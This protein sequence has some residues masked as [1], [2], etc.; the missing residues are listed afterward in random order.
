MKKHPSTY[1][2]VQRF[3][4]TLLLS[5]LTLAWAQV[6]EIWTGTFRYMAD[7]NIFVACSGERYEVIPDEAYLVLEQRY[8]NLIKDAGEALFVVLSGQVTPDVNMEG[9]LTDMFLLESVVDIRAD[10]RCP[11]QTSAVLPADDI[12][13]DG[14][15]WLILELP[16]LDQNLI[17][18]VPVTSLPYLEFRREGVTGMLTGFAGCNQISAAYLNRDARLLIADITITRRGCPGEVA[19]KLEAATLDALQDADSYVIDGQMLELRAGSEPVGL[20]FYEAP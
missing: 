7:A 4:F 3:I 12:R 1:N 19:S 9:K 20:F 2:L 13:L 15:R 8:I 10:G 5:L 11:E 16:Q 18:D 6:P 17:L 14:G